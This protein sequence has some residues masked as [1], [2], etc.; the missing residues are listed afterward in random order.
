MKTKNLI[1]ILPYILFLNSCSVSIENDFKQTNSGKAILACVSGDGKLN[2]NEIS[3]R[4][5]SK[6]I[7]A[8]IVKNEKE[9]NLQFTVNKSLNQAKLIGAS[10]KDSKDLTKFGLMLNLELLCGG[11]ISSKILPEEYKNLQNLQQ[12]RGIFN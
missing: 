11:E 6:A 4:D 9:I 3:L 12:L 1:L 8:V 10:I 5:G 2:F 7:E